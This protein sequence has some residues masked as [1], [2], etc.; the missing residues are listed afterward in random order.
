V[1]TA[2]AK[3]IVEFPVFSA[4]ALGSVVALEASHTSDPALDAAM[5]LCK[6]IVHID[7]GPVL[8]GLAQ[9]SADRSGVGTMTVCRDR[10]RLNA[11]GRPR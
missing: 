6:A 10:V 3:K 9:H 11:H 4:E 7:T 2:L 8:H 5:V 1:T